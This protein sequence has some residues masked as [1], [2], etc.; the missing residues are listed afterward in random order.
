MTEG[1]RLNEL[2]DEHNALKQPT[3]SQHQKLESQYQNLEAEM[4]VL[5]WENESIVQQHATLT[6]EL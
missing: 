1:T 3:D 4:L 2:Q 6:V 5:K